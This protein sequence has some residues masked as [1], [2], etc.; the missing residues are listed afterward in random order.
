MLHFLLDIS[1]E[2]A[3]SGSLFNT[4]ERYEWYPFSRTSY[5]RL[6]LNT[7]DTIKSSIALDEDKIYFIKS[8]KTDIELFIKLRFDYFLKDEFIINYIEK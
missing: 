6:E 2:E 4:T 8:D 5:K 1:S 7:L 3:L